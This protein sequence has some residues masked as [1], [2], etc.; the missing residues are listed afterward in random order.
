MSADV[1]PPRPGSVP[2]PSGRQFHISHGDQRATIVEVGGGIREYVNDGR[3]VLHPYALEDIADGAH[4]A[5]LIP[6]PNRVADGRYTFDGSDYQLAL[7][8]PEKHNAIHGLLRWRNWDRLDRSRER[9][10]VGTRLHPLTGWPFLLDVSIAYE[11]GDEGLSVETRVTNIGQRPCPFASGQHPY[12]SPGEGET[13]DGC[14]LELRAGTRVLT[15][16]ERQLPT[17]R[18]P[19]AGT[20][21][22]FGLPRRIGSLELDDAFTDVERDGDGRAWMRLACLD[23]RTVELWADASYPVLQLYTADTLAPVRRRRGLAVEPMT[24][25]PNAL[26]SGEMLVRLAPGQDHV[27]RWGVRLV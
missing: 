10:V 22:D 3:D 26:Q 6:W 8:E 18:E 19:V 12:V 16:S 4:G 11:L 24:A 25:P 20:D 1:T 23:G 27:T 17:G 5:P 9:I 13:V 2:C 15:D 21:Y 7:T 14:V